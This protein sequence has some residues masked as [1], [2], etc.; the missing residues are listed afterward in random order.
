MASSV[1]H[2]KAAEEVLAR[3]AARQDDETGRTPPSPETY[4][5]WLETAKL[6]TALAGVAL[7]AEQLLD[8]GSMFTGNCHWLKAL[9]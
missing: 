3:I 9:T 7:A 6:H 4:H 2:F 8:T 1:H 5:L